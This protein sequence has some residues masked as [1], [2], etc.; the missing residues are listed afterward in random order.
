MHA[1][2]GMCLAKK[3][4]YLSHLTTHAQMIENNVT[5]MPNF[6]F[7]IWHRFQGKSN[8]T[9]PYVI[10][11]ANMK[12]FNILNRRQVSI[13]EPQRIAKFA[14]LRRAQIVIF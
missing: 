12:F 3:Y 11:C 10:M 4:V 9:V 14:M 5:L 13:F 2:F 7:P 8:T 1:V 6:L